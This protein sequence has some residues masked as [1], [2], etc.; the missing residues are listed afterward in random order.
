MR[1]DFVE[2]DTELT[3]AHAAE[4]AHDGIGHSEASRLESQ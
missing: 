3:G 4:H 1:E 2:E